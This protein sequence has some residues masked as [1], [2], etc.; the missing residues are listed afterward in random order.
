M[1]NRRVIAV[2]GIVG[3]A[4]LLA[5]PLRDDVFRLFII[6]LAY[7]FW[8]LSLIYHAVRQTIWWA[9][10]MLVVLF[11][12]SKSLLPQFKARKRV[13]LKAKPMVGQ[14]ES[15]ATWIKKTEQGMY[16][17]WLIANR[18]GKIA[19]Q[20]LANRSTGRQR[21]FFDPLTG[22]DWTPDSAV[23]SYL[24]SG[25]HGSFADYPQ[26]SSFF[27]TPVQTPLDHDLSEVVQ[28]LESQVEDATH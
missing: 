25:L 26:K 8:V 11:L 18:L 24:E 7:V 14:V 20:I 19:N 12:V 6:P 21:T 17:K 9:L 15:F 13:P 16:F 1:R 10:A 28:Y 4:L 27:S 22:P 2:I 5:F 23:R 3:I